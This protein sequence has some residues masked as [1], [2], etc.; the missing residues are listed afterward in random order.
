MK[1]I[2]ITSFIEELRIIPHWSTSEA[3]ESLGCVDVSIVR[4]ISK[5]FKKETNLIVKMQK[6]GC[7]VIDGF[8]RSVLHLAKW[9]TEGKISKT[10]RAN[11]T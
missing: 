10:I 4:E 3:I 6:Y 11:H 7:I 1:L 5:T 8:P 2:Q 9:A